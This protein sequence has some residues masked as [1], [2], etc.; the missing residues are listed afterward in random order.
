VSA[1]SDVVAYLQRKSSAALGRPVAPTETDMLHKY[2]ILLI[3]WQRSQRLVGS[4]EPRWIV[5]NIIVDS[6][7][8]RRVLPVSI[9]RLADVGSGAGVPGI[10]LAVVMPSSAVELIEARQ[11]R[12]SFLAAVIRELTLRN[13]RLLN[14]RLEEVRGELAG[15]FNAVV[16]R[17]A[18]NPTSLV[19][20]VSAILAPG[21]VVVASGPPRRVRISAGAWL[22]VEGPNGVRRFW[23][24]HAT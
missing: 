12:G 4:D 7:L 3:K 11:K 13:C 20:D 15:R 17:C 18:G 22:E 19:A 2:L 1:N 5:D 24:Y 6:L 10:P 8:F 9:A 21:G 14:R 23:V 16:M